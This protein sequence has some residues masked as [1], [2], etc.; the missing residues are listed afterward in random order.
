TQMGL[1]NQGAGLLQG[2]AAGQIPPWATNLIRQ[3]NEPYIAQLGSQ[4]IDALRN[5]GFSGA[6]PQDVTGGMYGM[7]DRAT[8]AAYA[9]LPGQ[10]AQQTLNFLPGFAQSL[11]APGQ[12]AWQNQLNLGQQYGQTGIS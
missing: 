3:A 5:R 7:N 11:M 1:Y 9:N 4:S 12:Q 6:G 2:M 8:Q 10:E